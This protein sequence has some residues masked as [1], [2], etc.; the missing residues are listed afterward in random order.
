LRILLVGQDPHVIGGVENYTRPLA[1]KF[2]ELGHDV[3]YFF[4]GA[5]M[6]KYNWLFKPYLKINR[7]D[8]PFECAELINSPL[9]SHNFHN[10][11][12][13]IRSPKIERIFQKYIQEIKPDIM[14]MH[15]RCGLPASLAGIAAES[16]IR[17]F[18]TIHI[19]GLICMKRVMIRRDGKP[20]EGPDD[21]TECANC[22]ELR[23]INKLKFLARINSTHENLLRFFV[24]VK[25]KFFQKEAGGKEEPAAGKASRKEDQ[26]RKMKISLEN[27]LKAM[28]EM[29]NTHMVKNICVSTT[30]KE[31]C[32]RYGVREDKLMVQH[33]GSTIAETQKLEER[34]LHNPLVIG[35]IGGINHYKGQHVLV[36]AVEKLGRQDFSV[37]LF[38]KYDRRYVED[39]MKGR[40]HLPVQ[41][42]GKY[43]HKDLPDILSQIDV[44]VLTSICADTAPQ[45]IFESH[46]AGIP[47]VA[48]DIGGF[49]DFVKD[50][51]NGYLFRP[52][53]SRHLSEKL[54]I[55]L[56]NPQRINHFA[57]NIPH[58]KTITENARELVSLYQES[59]GAAGGS[60]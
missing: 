28:V 42:L 2:A 48:S 59:L 29:M 50:G 23:N 17:V 18:N 10:P 53:D 47:I 46:S 25:K 22:L 36:E 51:V 1:V 45:T 6:R 27:R 5:W 32:L 16:G 56:D 20:C 55:L 8:F 60:H 49:P 57:K 7:R 52:G 54:R 33:I 11:S 37:K 39:M 13:D 43:E 14:H 3:F 12:L 40:D 19:Y 21:L 26:I 30:V 9:W 35:N 4:S 15:S 44:M 31:T 58:L 34:P 41:F 24:R 38:G